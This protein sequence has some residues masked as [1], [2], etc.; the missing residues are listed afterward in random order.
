[1]FIPSRLPSTLGL[2]GTILIAGCNGHSPSPAP[3]PPPPVASLSV[4][5]PG[6]QAAGS[7]TGSAVVTYPPPTT[8]GGT[9][10]V[11][12]KCTMPSGT[13]FPVGVSDVVCTAT[14]SVNRT[15]SCVFHVD[16]SLQVK[17]KGTRFLAFGDSI[18]GGE[19]AAPNSP[20]D[21][22]PDLSYPTVLAQS[23]IA[24]YASQ[25]IAMTNCGQYG[26]QAVADTGRLQSV[27]AGG[28][29]GPTIPM[30]RRQFDA[31]L[32]DALLL[33]E[34]TNDLNGNDGDSSIIGKVTE[35]L[36]ADIRRAKT[37]GVQQVFLSTLP[38]EFGLGG[39]M[40][41]DMNDAIRA[42]A[43]SEGVIL[44]DNYTA[45]GGAT[46]TLI[47]VGGIHPTADGYRVM[48]QTFLTAIEANFEVP[49]ASASALRRTRR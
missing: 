15:A 22:R 7:S 26:Q 47:G 40:V 42:L 1:M 44:V 18:T 10:P 6:D 17:L 16:V 4:Q 9:A 5:C 2:A 32:F 23:L 14:D 48:A 3:T 37:A 29:C 11:A 20:L 24:R 45:L 41:P 21:Y 49:P 27:L 35:A 34:G 19:V 36:K 28:S 38:P 31:S 46:S 8:T 13:A 43:A 33:L 25:T 30:G 39:D 12:T